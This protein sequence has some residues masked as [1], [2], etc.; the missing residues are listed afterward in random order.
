MSITNPYIRY[1]PNYFFQV[2]LFILIRRYHG[3]MFCKCH[4]SF[5][6]LAKLYEIKIA[7]KF[8]LFQII[9]MIFHLTKRLGVSKAIVCTT[10]TPRAGNVQLFIY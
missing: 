3:R 1:V 9:H 7:N 6:I 10:L 2:L 5:I 8:F 4:V